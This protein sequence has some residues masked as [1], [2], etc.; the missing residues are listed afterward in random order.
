MDVPDI[1][2]HEH[3]PGAIPATA[4]RINVAQS[5]K[6]LLT[7]AYVSFDYDK[8]WISAYMGSVGYPAGEDCSLL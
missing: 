2:M 3:T 1:F 4:T 7:S 8:Q 6:L 5:R